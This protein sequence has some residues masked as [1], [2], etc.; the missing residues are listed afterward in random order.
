MN[1][2]TRIIITKKRNSQSEPLQLV[3]YKIK[4]LP[5]GG[6]RPTKRKDMLV[7]EAE[8]LAEISSTAKVMWR[9]S[10]RLSRQ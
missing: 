3:C 5:Y 8:V 9:L 2:N 10:R 6:K 4:N 1:D 7:L